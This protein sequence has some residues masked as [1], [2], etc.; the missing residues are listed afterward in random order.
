MEPRIVELGEEVRTQFPLNTKMVAIR[1]D[2][3]PFALVFDLDR[4]DGEALSALTRRAWLI[5]DGVS[6]MDLPLEDVRV[7]VGLFLGSELIVEAERPGFLRYAC[8]A[9]APRMVGNE[10]RG[11]P[12]VQLGVV[13][14][15]VVGLI[16][17]SG[18]RGVSEPGLTWAERTGLG[19]DEEFLKAWSSSGS[20]M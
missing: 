16:S 11:S 10:I 13:A 12:Y 19:T 4:P 18:C 3:I 6:S 5:F 9:L 2:L 14:K 17:V 7:P 8:S 1:W 20:S 15:R